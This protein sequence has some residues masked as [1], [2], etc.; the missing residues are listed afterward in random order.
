MVAKWSE[1]VD[2]LEALLGQK[3]VLDQDIQNK[4]N[5][6]KN[7][8]QTE[9]QEWDD[10][11]DKDLIEIPMNPLLKE[12]VDLGGAEMMA[13][14][15]NV[16]GTAFVS[17]LTNNTAALALAWPVIEKIGFFIW[18]AI[19]AYRTHTKEGTAFSKEFR[20]NV[21][22]GIKNLIV[23]ITMHDSIYTLVMTYG[24]THEMFSATLLSF[25][26]FL[27][28]LPPAILMKY[29]GNELLHVLQK[30]YS[31]FHGFKR[32]KYYEA[33][34][35][36]NN[37]SNPKAIFEKIGDKFWLGGYNLSRYHDTYFHH[38]I[39]SFS[40]RLGTVK[41][42][43][44]T[45]I[46]GN[47]ESSNA[48]EIAHTLPTKKTPKKESM[49][50]YF[51]SRKEKGTKVLPDDIEGRDILKKFPYRNIIKDEFAQLEFDREILYDDQ[52][53]ITLDQITWST[54]NDIRKMIEIKAYNDK[55]Y[56]MEVMCAIMGDKHT[57]SHITT[58]P[59]IKFFEKK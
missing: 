18:E 40:D 50:N 5:E 12:T 54:N 58:H 48:F 57:D 35:I 44:I 59:K 11:D 25:I 33:R 4:I 31:R 1:K 52:I 17:M 51:Y 37:H 2:N 3:W 38:R 26:S 30:Q 29:S 19:K 42:R 41:L 14:V 20:S 49:Y 53:R 45:D 8:F 13:W 24:L 7:T 36:V 28:A 15:Y 34:F 55:K 43:N 21:S 56:L 23:D 10:I 22:N 16:L 6:L 32:E 46:T 9:K 27:V 39:P 47:N